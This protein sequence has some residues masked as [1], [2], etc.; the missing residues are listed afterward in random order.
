MTIFHENLIRLKKRD[1]A[2]AARVESN[3]EDALLALRE[4]PTPYPTL[5][6]QHNGQTFALHHPERP[7]EHALEF[8]ESVEGLAALRNL[9]LFGCGLGYVPL[10]LRERARGLRHLYVLEP[11]LSVFRTALQRMDLTA[12]LGD[13]AVEW[14]IAEK[15]T[16]AFP[17]LTAHLPDLMANSVTMLEYPPTAGAFPEWTASMKR[18]VQEAMR[19]GQS[20]MLTKFKDGPLTLRN[21]LRNL[22]TLTRARG[23]RDFGD[24]FR[25]APAVIAA[26]GPSLAKS[27]HQLKEAA[28]HCLVIAVDTALEPLRA[29]GIEPH[30]VVT[31]DPTE[32][33]LRHFPRDHYGDTP[34]LLFDPE[35]R[36]EIAAR[37]DRPLTAMT[38][39]HDFFQWLDERLGGVGVIK[40]G[41]MVSQMGLY[42]AEFLGCD[43]IIL[44]GQ[45][46]ALDSAEGWT[47]LP[48]AALRRQAGFIEGDRDH[49]DVP[50]IDEKTSRENLYW[51]EGV[52]GNPVPTVQSFLVYIHML[53]ND[54]ARMKARVIDATEGGAKI[55]GTQVMTLAEAIEQ[56]KTI[57]FE[58]SAALT[59]ADSAAKREPVDAEALRRE[60]SERLDDRLNDAR[61]AGERMRALGAGDIEACFEALEEARKMLFSHPADEYL[62]EY[63]APRALFE[64]LKLGPGDITEDQMLV[65]CQRRMDALTKAVEEAHLQLKEVL[66]SGEA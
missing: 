27:M 54:I 62:I 2:L 12:L 7:L 18:Q 58:P 44:V 17:R 43:P 1:A 34:W 3:E 38:D 22:K 46:L 41:G 20:G 45:D 42:A 56:A 6:V 61:Q 65:E 26:A 16:G 59:K 63:A 9:I 55:P 19:L 33:N 57:G 23:L 15:E 51:V 28:E 40:K 35:S 37:F 8:V 13:P 53:A 64:F 39:K 24:A 52:D 4:T 30:W 32:L 60:L 49:V 31:V 21:L 5:L 48:G 25:G 10:L 14:I 50:L 47:H 11:S 36:P 66:M 29:Q